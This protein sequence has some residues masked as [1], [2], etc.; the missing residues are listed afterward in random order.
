LLRTE[1]QYTATRIPCVM[2]VRS[3]H[4]IHH[5]RQ[6]P[7]IIHPYIY[8]CMEEAGRRPRWSCHG[9]HVT[10]IPM[11]SEAFGRNRVGGKDRAWSHPLTIPAQVTPLFQA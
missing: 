5:R 4:F 7:S 2:H 8:S 11:V 10:G 3:R 1:A 9:N 6:H